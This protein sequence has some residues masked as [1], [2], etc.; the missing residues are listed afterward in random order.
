MYI[1]FF[2]INQIGT[3]CLSTVYGSLPQTALQWIITLEME[4]SNYCYGDCYFVQVDFQER[5]W[6][7]GL[8]L[9]SVMVV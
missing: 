8:R 3:F 1:F 2:N 9:T 5:S 7:L 6:L 4:V